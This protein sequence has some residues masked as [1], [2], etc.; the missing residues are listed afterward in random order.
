VGTAAHAQRTLDTVKQRGKLQC[1]ISPVAPGFSHLN[2]QGLRQGFD[3][4]I[5]R[6]VAAGI[7]GDPEKVEFTPLDTNVRFQAVQSGRVDILAAQTTWTFSRDASLG[8][9]FGPI[10]FH[11]G[12]GIMVRSDLGVKN[13]SELSGAAICLLPGTTSLQ[14]L[15]D[16]FRPRAI[17][18]EAVVFENSDEW[19]NAFLSGRCD[20]ITADRS[21]IVSV[22]SMAN[23]PNRYVIL[24]E[25]ISYEPLAPVLRSND[26][27]WR[28][29]VSWTIYALITAER[30]GVTRANIESFAGSNDPEVQ[31]LLG[32]NG[33]FGRMI[34]L[35][36]RWA[37]NAIKAVGNYGEILNRHFG[38]D[39]SMPL[40][41]GPNRLWTDGGLIYSPP[42]R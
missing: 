25:V 35:H 6:A 24:P 41:R 37:F 11:D 1:G 21:V 42:F 27:S 12:Q 20:A 5:C 33:D 28:D 39:S 32:S 16:Y 14:N 8:L 15:E 38:P 40:D 13:A 22:R 9:D 34:S 31:R 36:N 4:D 30:K 29:I 3:V 18:Y 7:F 17:R 26:A 10:I 2:D 23:D 19:R